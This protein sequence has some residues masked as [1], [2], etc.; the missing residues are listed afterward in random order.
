MPLA[1]RGANGR[2]GRVEH[3]R[4]KSDAVPQNRKKWMLQP[5]RVGA[6]RSTPTRTNKVAMTVAARPWRPRGVPTPMIARRSRPRLKP[7]AWI[8]NRLRMF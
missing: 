3:E 2:D 6:R 5:D 4:A 1:A 8:S 7:P